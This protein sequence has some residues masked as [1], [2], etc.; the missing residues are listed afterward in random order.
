MFKVS[1]RLEEAHL[2]IDRYQTELKARLP[3]TVTRAAFAYVLAATSVIPVWS[4][5][6]HATFTELA[7]AIGLPLAISPTAGDRTTLGTSTSSGE[8]NT[9][10]AMASFTYETELPHLIYNEAVNANINPDR[11]LFS[12][13][14]QPGP[15][16]FQAIAGAAATS[17]MDTFVGPT[18]KINKRVIRKRVL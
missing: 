8:L 16:G 7:S 4:G 18:P 2:D 9:G 1:V 12:K 10:N 11:S 17:V 3:E 14:L 13:L 6:S 5:A 15:Y